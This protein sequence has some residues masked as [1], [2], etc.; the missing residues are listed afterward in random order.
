MTKMKTLLVLL[1]M[2][3]FTNAQVIIENSGCNYDFDLTGIKIAI[4]FTD[5][6]EYNEATVIPAY[7]NKW[8]AEIIYVGT[9]DIISSH[10]IGLGE[11]G[12][13]MTEHEIKA[14]M[15]LNDFNPANVDVVY[16]PGGS[17]PSNLLKNNF[18]K[19]NNITQYA[20]STNKFIAGFCHGPQILID[21]R[22]I[23][24]KK[25]TGE[26]NDED[27]INAGGIP[28]HSKAAADGN[29]ITGNFPY[30]ESFAITF[31]KHINPANILRDNND[32]YFENLDFTI[33]TAEHFETKPVHESL[34]KK[35]VQAASLTVYD[36][37]INAY[38]PWQVVAVINSEV[39][40]EMQ[41]IFR[42]AIGKFYADHGISEDRRKRYID[43]H[44][45]APVYLVVTIKNKLYDPRLGEYSL[46]E[47]INSK[48][49]AVSAGAF[50]NDLRVAADKLG[51]GTNMVNGMPVLLAES[52]IRNMLDISGEYFIAGVV[53]LGY[54][55]Q[56]NYPQ[57]IRPGN[58]NV[59]IK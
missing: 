23:H 24:G 1:L 48:M 38:K 6:V 47:S 18:D 11:S 19:I 25:I 50:I 37:T 40:H 56:C 44:I 33:A 5:D 45:P 53:A 52:E 43:T 31:A 51:L 39:N 34:I 41:N 13:S 9:S 27:I 28:I 57:P 42:S 29:I 17:S 30:L 59:I 36:F 22:V 32:A 35:I 2:N 26:V 20:D 12:F 55:Q 3:C 7:W 16:F 49:L 21:T 46:D 54:T 10:S 58:E 14:D 8:G 15:L 4:I